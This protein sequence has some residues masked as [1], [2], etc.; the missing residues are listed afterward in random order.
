MKTKTF[1]MAVFAVAIVMV[2]YSFREQV[3]ERKLT[4]DKTEIP[5]LKK[6]PEA[7]QLAAKEMMKKY[8]VPD[9]ATNSILVWHNNGPWKKTVIFNRESKHSFP[10]DHTD[11]ME[12]VIN[13]K[14][15]ASKMSELGEYDGSIIVKR[16][17]GMM[18]AKCDKEG[19]NF[20]AINLANDIITGKKTVK[21]ARQFYAN[22][23]KDFVL[24][25][26]MSPYMQSFQFTASSANEGDKDV[27]GV[28]EAENEQITKKMMEMN[29][30]MLEKEMGMR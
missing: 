27:H 21:E 16:T 19:A 15:P 10:V 3:E 25:N 29:K 30:M 18:A 4:K 5:D 2:I 7:S 11:V 12:Q 9:E 1:F 6:W 17:D 13:Y 28:S 14:V 26:K 23:I 24:N 22:T 8:G 20:L